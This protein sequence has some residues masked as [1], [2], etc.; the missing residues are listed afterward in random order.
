MV[1]VEKVR[2]GRVRVRGIG[3]FE[4]GDRA[5][6]SEEDAAYLCDERGDFERVGDAEVENDAADDTGGYLRD[7]PAAVQIDEGVCPWCPPNDRY[8]GDGVPQHASAAHPDE[9]AEYK[10]N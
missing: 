6:V 2:G 5:D 8:E 10:E 9:W 4:R 7:Q 1:T 3:R